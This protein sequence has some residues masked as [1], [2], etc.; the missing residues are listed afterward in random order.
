MGLMREGLYLS[1]SLPRIQYESHLLTNLTNVNQPTS[2]ETPRTRD[3]R[4]REQR[5]RVYDLAIFG[6]QSKHQS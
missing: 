3:G 1:A 2:H 6:A 5:E 4:E